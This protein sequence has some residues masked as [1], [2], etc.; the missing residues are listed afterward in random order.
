MA[1]TVVIVGAGPAGVAAAATL[2]EE[3]FDGR[4]ILI[5]AEHQPPCERPP[6]SKEYLRGESPFEQVLLRPPDFY[7]ENAR[8]RG[9]FALIRHGPST[10][11]GPCSNL[12]GTGPTRRNDGIATVESA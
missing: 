5:G 4:L 7:A 2:R 12:L 9:K 8:E 11:P 3:G 10:I 6:L 1:E